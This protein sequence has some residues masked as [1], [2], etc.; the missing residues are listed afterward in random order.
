[1]NLDEG[2]LACAAMTPRGTLLQD[3]VLTWAPLVRGRSDRVRQKLMT[4]G[5]G[6]VSSRLRV[7]SSVLTVVGRGRRG[8]LVGGGYLLTIEGEARLNLRGVEREGSL[9]IW[10]SRV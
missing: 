4:T 8:N 5:E 7:R 6:A 10:G 9:G 3:P 2:M 1:M